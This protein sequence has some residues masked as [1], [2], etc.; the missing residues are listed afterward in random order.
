M[1]QESVGSPAKR[2]V[3]SGRLSSRLTCRRGGNQL[4][5]GLV[6]YPN[7]GRSSL[8]NVMMVTGRCGESSP[9][10]LGFPA[11][12][13]DGLFTTVDPNITTFTL[14][15]E[16]HDYL[17]KVYAPVLEDQDDADSEDDADL[18]TATLLNLG[19]AAG[20]ATAAA[21]SP[22]GGSSQQLPPPQRQHQ[23]QAARGRPEVSFADTRPSLL[24]GGGGGAGGAGSV[25]ALG[26]SAPAAEVKVGQRVPG[27]GNRVTLIDPAA[28]VPGSL[29][30]SGLMGGVIGGP[31]GEPPRQ[32]LAVGP[33]GLPVMDSVATAGLGYNDC[34]ALAYADA[35]VVVLRGFAD[36]KLTHYHET[37]DP[38][39]DF[40]AVHTELMARDV[41][42]LEAALLR[43]ARFVGDGTGGSDTVF[44]YDTLMRAW[45]HLTGTS[46]GALTQRLVVLLDRLAVGSVASGKVDI[47]EEQVAARKYSPAKLRSPDRPVPTKFKWNEGIGARCLGT[48]R[49]A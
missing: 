31:R 9:D 1:P 36:D 42:R 41:E 18:M 7:A 34:L 39:R 11:T 4:R 40:H 15:D 13:D 20:A 29:S 2:V 26:S 35:L 45:E 24:R 3:G 14:A 5:I 38:V 10:E 47:D 43:L 8:Y 19:T 37:V 33:G 32:S 16:R 21:L 22:A 30:H 23:Q 12:V 17:R 25:A 44:E 48:S 46:R 6:G 27:A 49:R 28:F